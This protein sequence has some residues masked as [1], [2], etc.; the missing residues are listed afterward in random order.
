ML[1]KRLLEF[2]LTFEYI[3]KIKYFP[4]VLASIVSFPFI[5]LVG[6]AIID[7]LALPEDSPIEDYTPGGFFAMLIAFFV[8]LFIAGKIASRYYIKYYSDTQKPEEIVIDQVLGQMLTTCLC[9]PCFLLSLPYVQILFQY[10]HQYCFLAALFILQ[11]ILFRRQINSADKIIK[12]N[13]DIMLNSIVA[14][15]VASLYFYI[16]A[17]LTG[18]TYCELLSYIKKS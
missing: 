2:F 3:G 6:S 11:I 8:I 4:G 12:A 1:K 9:L 16:I 7:Y 5:Y 10:L 18:F 13:T 17:L 14:A 15:F